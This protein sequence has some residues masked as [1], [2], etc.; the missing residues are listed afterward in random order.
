MDGLQSR[1]GSFSLP[2]A[3]RPPTSGANLRLPLGPPMPFRHSQPTAVSLR[4]RVRL[5]GAIAASLLAL[6]PLALTPLAAQ[7]T[8]LRLSALERPVE[9]LRDRFGV[10][11]IYADTEHDLF[12]AQGWAA[13]RDRLFQFELW[14]RQATGTV[15]E[16]LGPR[17]LQRDIGARLFR[18]RGDLEAELAH[19]HP[20]GAAIIRAFTDG[21]NAYV[22]QANASPETLPIEFK[23]LDTRPERWTPDVVISR[24]QGLLGNVTQELTVGRAVATL[25][26]ERVKALEAYGPGDPDLT[27]APG[28]DSAILAQNILGVYSAFRGGVQFR[29]ADVIASARAPASSR[30]EGEGAANETE[31]EVDDAWTHNALDIGSNNWV[32][33]PQRTESGYPIMANDPHRAQGAPSLRYMVHL[34]GPGWNVIGGGEPVL[35]GVSIGHNEHGAW[36]LTIFSTD[37]EDLLVYDTDPADP[38][39]YRFRGEWERMRVIIDTVPVKGRA[40]EVV[41]HRY[42]RHGPVVF[43]DRAR[44]KAFA[45]RAA[46]MEVG[47]APYLA[48]LRLGAARNVA[49]FLEAQRYA[50]IPAEN[51]IWADRSGEIAWQAVGIAP[52]RPNFS[53]L[54]PVPGDGRFE[55]DGFL[56]IREKPHSVNPPQGFFATA[57]NDLIP[58]DYPHMDAIGF[59]WSDPYR[60][61][62]ANEVLASGTRHSIADM[63]R[64][65]TDEYS[66]PARQL[67]P[68]LRDLPLSRARSDSLRRRLLAWDRVLARESI[69]AGLYVAFEAQLRRIVY[70]RMVRPAERALVRSVPLRNVVKWIVAPPGAFGASPLAAR[71]SLLVSALE[72]ADAEMTRRFGADPAAWV[73]GQPA[74]KHALIRHPLSQAV[75][76]ETRSLLDVGPL[77]RGGYAV[78]L[79]ATGG[80]DNQTSGA[81]FRIIVDLAD[82][83]LAVGTNTPGQSGDAS[84]PHYRD[85]FESWANDRYFPVA[86]SRA[87]VESLTETRLRLEPGGG[88]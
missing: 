13:A 83:D 27:L 45:V 87:R 31:R 68:L 14:R 5:A 1:D 51:M 36:G 15:A 57:N 16:L 86:Y 76:D 61:A 38:E 33:S 63:M 29:P 70:D 73:Y 82:W 44:N 75:N 88:R 20:R 64:L 72:R 56:D 4:A 37:G 40:S 28:L 22:D 53:G 39:R 6:A 50:H 8:T 49:D 7:P 24:H 26:A 69:D 67:V 23:L 12:V 43:R 60:W 52:R 71:D 34:V 11:H 42:T 66:I 58:R 81:S 19:Y 74:Y 21:V 84:S 41:E 55:W 18:F 65:Q 2:F 78:T 35:P 80:G 85:L 79:N 48:S 30:G 77:P 10:N 62:R 3:L 47:G 54:V 17:E 25:G 59:S 46:W 32:V 9:I